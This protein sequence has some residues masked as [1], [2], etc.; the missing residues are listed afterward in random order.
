MGNKVSIWE[1]SYKFNKYKNV[2][3][4][5]IKITMLCISVFTIASIVFFACND[6]EDVEENNTKSIVAGLEVPENGFMFINKHKAFDTLTVLMGESWKDFIRQYTVVNNRI[7]SSPIEMLYAFEDV[8]TI[9]VNPN[10]DSTAFAFIAFGDEFTIFDIQDARDGSVAYKITHTDGDTVCSNIYYAN[11][12]SQRFLD[13][14]CSSRTFDNPFESLNKSVTIGVCIALVGVL[15]AAADVAVSLYN[16]NCTNSLNIDMNN[17]NN[18]HLYSKR[19][20]RCHAVCVK[21]KQQKQK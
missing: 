13:I 5:I 7:V 20:G 18:R 6:K 16:N 21:C 2:K 15:I 10:R 19:N 11:L 1:S 8:G 12:T 9:Q 14:L 17:C 4:R 3:K